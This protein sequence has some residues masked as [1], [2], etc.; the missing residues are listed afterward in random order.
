MSL[1]TY[2]VLIEMTSW[3]LGIYE[4]L[5]PLESLSVEGLVRVLGPRGT[6]ALPRPVS[7]YGYCHVT[8]HVIVA[9]FLMRRGYE[10]KRIL[11]PLL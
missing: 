7:R 4:G 5:K 11:I 6:P 1:I 8:A 9:W 2:T 10:L 3:V